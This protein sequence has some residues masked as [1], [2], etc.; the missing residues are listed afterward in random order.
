MEEKIGCQIFSWC[1]LFMFSFQ[2]ISEIL[3]NL[4]AGVEFEAV[5]VLITRVKP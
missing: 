3:N 5:Q 1:V 2:I 4:R